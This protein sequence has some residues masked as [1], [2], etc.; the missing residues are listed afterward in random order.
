MLSR[1]A[2]LPSL[3]TITAHRKF[4]PFGLL[5]SDA[6]VGKT[7]DSGR[8]NVQ[9]NM[10]CQR[11]QGLRFLWRSRRVARRPA[12]CWGSQILGLAAIVSEHAH[13]KLGYEGGE[14]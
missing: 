3:R 5:S 1:P 11:I 10:S 9:S 14:Q 4:N 7:G 8:E 12:G 2:A 13:E 6:S